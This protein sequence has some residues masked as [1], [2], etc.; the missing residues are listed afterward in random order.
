[1][2]YLYFLLFWICQIVSTIIF[3]Y[4]GIHPKYHWSALVAGN[5]ILITASWFL[6]Q[7]FKTFPQP[8]VIALCSGGTFLTV[9][10]AMALVFKQHLTWM[11]ILGSTIIVIGMVLVTFGGKE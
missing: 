8:I 2:N 5:I 10:L 3:K 4:G 1:M 11:Q 7:L 9:Q 6:I